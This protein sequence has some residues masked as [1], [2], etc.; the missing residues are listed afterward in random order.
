MSTNLISDVKV[1]V[2][3]HLWSEVFTKGCSPRSD[4][5]AIAAKR[6]ADDEYI[7]SAITHAGLE[8]VVEG[9]EGDEIIVVDEAH[10]EFYPFLAY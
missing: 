5:A 4:L 6:I 8:F 7:A 10:L 3:D 2:P 9:E 1:F